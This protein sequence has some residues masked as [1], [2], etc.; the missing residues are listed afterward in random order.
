MYIS[1]FPIPVHVTT[2]KITHDRLMPLLIAS[3]Y[4]M[5]MENE[6]NGLNLKTNK[7]FCSCTSYLLQYAVLK[8][9]KLFAG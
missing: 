1:K 5:A 3:Q 7:L 8:V 6:G 2:I 4:L 9:M